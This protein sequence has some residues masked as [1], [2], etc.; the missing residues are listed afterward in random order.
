MK[1]HQMKKLLIAF[2]T[3]VLIACQSATTKKETTPPKNI[4]TPKISYVDLSGAE[5]KLS[6]YKGKKV[7]VNYWATWCGPCIKEMP[8]LLKAQEIL[9]ESNYVF[10]LVSD[11]SAEKISNF[12]SKKSYD[13]NFLKLKGSFDLLGI[14]ALPTTYVYNEKGEKVKE[15]VGS[16]IWDS[17]EMIQT[18][19]NI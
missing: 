17:K 7:L 10:L 16:V 12:K 18:L 6:D 4:K 9:K 3:I 1:I 8:A 2:F 19:K 14:Y 13:F 5:V 15:I 11:E